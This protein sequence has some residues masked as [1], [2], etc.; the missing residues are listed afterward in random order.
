MSREVQITN[1]LVIKRKYLCWCQACMWVRILLLYFYAQLLY[2]WYF[3]QNFISKLYLWIY[4]F[5]N[6][7]IIYSL[8][9]SIYKFWHIKFYF[10]MKFLY[11]SFIFEHN[12]AVYVYIIL[13][14][15]KLYNFQFN[16]NNSDLDLTWYDS[17]V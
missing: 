11:R 8:L 1:F 2:F 7:S 9:F 5:N 13:Y 4:F 15:N 3:L 10:P 17:Q 12:C 14:L 16:L 6:S